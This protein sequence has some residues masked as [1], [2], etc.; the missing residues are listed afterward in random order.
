MENNH[1]T[2]K[3]Q[4]KAMRKAYAGFKSDGCTAVPDFNFGK[5]C[6]AE[7]DYHYTTQ[8]ISRWEADKRFRKC[9]QKK[10]YLVLP[11]VYW[12]GV[13]LFGGHLWDTKLP[14]NN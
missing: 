14:N 13:R 11:W 3:E 6:C 10:G 12:L 8:T 9:I 4:F 7:H 5:D 2:L 1:L